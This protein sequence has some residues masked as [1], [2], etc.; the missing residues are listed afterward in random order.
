MTMAVSSYR[1]R[2]RR[3]DEELRERLVEL[4]REKPR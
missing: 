2:N 4:A 3:S 1:Y